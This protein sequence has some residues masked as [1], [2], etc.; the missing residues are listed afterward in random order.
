LAVSSMTAL[1]S[2]TTE[3]GRPRT[4]PSPPRNDMLH[5]HMLTAHMPSVLA[6]HPSAILFSAEVLGRQ[7]RP[8][9]C[10]PDPAKSASER[11]ALQAYACRAY[12]FCACDPPHRPPSSRRRYSGLRRCPRECFRAAFLNDSPIWRCV[13]PDIRGHEL[14]RPAAPVPRS[15]QVSLGTICFTGICVPRIFFLSVLAIRLVSHPLLGRGAR[16]PTL[17]MRMRSRSVSNDSSMSDMRAR[18]F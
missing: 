13:T 9:E 12:A 3:L 11:Y 17:P 6:I 10:V 14:P 7:R 18:T 8:C 1:P 15:R 2:V 4:P 5:R 16:P